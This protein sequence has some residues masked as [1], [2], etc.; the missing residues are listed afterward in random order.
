MGEVEPVRRAGIDLEPRPRDQRRRPLAA[1]LIVAAGRVTLVQVVA[2]EALGALF[3]GSGLGIYVRFGFAGDDL[4]QIQAGALLVAG[5]AMAVDAAVWAGSRLLLPRW[6]PA[7][8]GAGR[9]RRPLDLTT[10]QPQG[11]TP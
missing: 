5:T 1:P 11:G 9:G 3:G 4:Y 2:T 8:P 7:P 10:I 6:G